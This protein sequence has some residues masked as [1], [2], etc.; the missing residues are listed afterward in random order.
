[1]SENIYLCNLQDQKIA[2]SDHKE[3]NVS[4]GQSPKNTKSLYKHWNH[5]D[6]QDELDYLLDLQK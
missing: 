1:M 5:E 6:E 4:D 2:E 3:E